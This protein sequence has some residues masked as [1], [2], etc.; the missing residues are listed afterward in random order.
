MAYWEFL[1]QQSGDQSWLPLE[2]S[3]VEILEGRYRIVAHTSHRD[4]AVDIY[5]TQWLQETVPPRRRVFRRQGQVNSEG[6]LAVMPFTQLGAGTWQVQC[7]AAGESP[8]PWDYGVELRVL[9]VEVDPEGWAPD[10]DLS[11]MTSAEVAQFPLPGATGD[12]GGNSEVTG[13]SPSPGVAATLSPPA[14]LETAPFTALPLRIYL[15]QQALVAASTAPVVLQGQVVDST[16]APQAIPEAIALWV[17]LRNP[18]TGAVVSRLGQS[19]IL[20]QGAFALSLPLPT[21]ENTRLLVGELS[22]WQGEPPV[23][24]AIQGF[25]V[26]TNLDTLLEVVARQGE[27]E[28]RALLGGEGQDQGLSADLSGFDPSAQDRS[29]SPAPRE[30]PFRPV[31]RPKAGLTLPPH[32]HPPAGTTPSPA[33][34]PPWAPPAPDSLDL[35]AFPRGDSPP[36]RD[37]AEPPPPPEPSGGLNTQDRFWSRLSALAQEGQ[38][39]TAHMKAEMEAAGVLPSPPSPRRGPPGTAGPSPHEVVIYDD[40]PDPLAEPESLAEEPL[41]QQEVLTAGF[42]PEAEAA[43]GALA[44]PVE[45]PIP[46]LELPE[47][48][49]VAG[50][51]I[52]VRVRLP[53]A[54]ERLAVKFWMTDL[55]SRRPV[56][57]PRWFMTWVPKQ[58]YQETLAQIQVPQGCLEVHF[59][60]I[61]VDLTHQQESRKAIAPRTILPAP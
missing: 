38:N 56:E 11:E 6:L 13:A 55:Q 24:I 43:L 30:I 29:T 18:E 2:T 35:P 26:T 21:V 48:D 28:G 7:R 27:Q 20:E 31:Y 32:V 12:G 23:A 3:H 33:E 14:N 4:A 45:V 15:S 54:A 42:S 58:D 39:T 49:L 53:L 22:L 19:L 37:T 10:W 8:A 59:E 36:A 47:G 40:E 51:A 41:T 50:S 1:L 57:K 52:T 61:A 44:A 46:T 17:Q 25:T 9:P 60:A 34:V 16:G 5:L